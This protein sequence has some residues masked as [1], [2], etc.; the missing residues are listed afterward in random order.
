MVDPS[1]GSFQT[2]AQRRAVDREAIEVQQVLELAQDGA[3]A[4]GGEEVFHV[5]LAD[6]LQVDEDRRFVRD[7]VEPLR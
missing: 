5:P 2:L 3:D 1:G 7:L 6:R 4:A